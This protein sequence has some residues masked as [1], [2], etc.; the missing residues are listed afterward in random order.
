MAHQQRQEQQRPVKQGGADES[1]VKL[2]VKSAL[3]VIPPEDL[4]PPIQVIMM[5]MTEVG[6]VFLPESHR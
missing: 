1:G 4:H 3:C 5:V 6:R 2:V